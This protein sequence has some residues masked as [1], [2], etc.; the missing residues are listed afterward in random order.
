[1]SPEIDE[2]NKAFKDFNVSMQALSEVFKEWGS[3]MSK[4]CDA[5]LKESSDEYKRH[6][7]RRVV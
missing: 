2:Y 4:C 7:G 3:A 1:M 6:T 5:M